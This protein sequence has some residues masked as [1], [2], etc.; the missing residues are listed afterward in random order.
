MAGQWSSF[1]QYFVTFTAGDQQDLLPL[2]LINRLVTMLYHPD[3]C[4]VAQWPDEGQP[5][6]CMAALPHIETLGIENVHL[7]H[8]AVSWCTIDGVLGGHVHPQTQLGP[9]AMSAAAAGVKYFLWVVIDIMSI[10]HYLP[11]N[12]IHSARSL[13]L[14]VCS[15]YLNHVFSHTIISQK[16]SFPTWLSNY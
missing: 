9:A 7:L 1:Q 6:S 4:I 3:T 10:T 11:I 13:L 12:S 8:A 15:S 14:L 16:I 2:G 5:V